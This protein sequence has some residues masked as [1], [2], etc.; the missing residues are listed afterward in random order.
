MSPKVGGVKILQVVLPGDEVLQF[1]PDGNRE[2]I[3]I[4]PGLR[5]QENII[6]ATRSGVLKKTSQNLYYIDNHQKR[7]IPQ[8]REFVIGIILKKN[9]DNYIIDIGGSEKAKISLMVFENS[10]KKTRKEM[11]PGDIIFGQVLVANKDI[12]PELVCI[13]VFDNS[14]GIGALPEDGIMFS[15][16]LHVAR[17]IVNPD[18]SFLLTIS[19]RIKFKIV[20]G[21]NGR[22]WLKA[23]R[24]SDMLAVMNCLLMLE[25]MPLKE[26][27]WNVFRMIDS[28]SVKSR[29]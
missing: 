27:E 2:C 21:F 26:A 12:E 8:K 5:W 1:N 23:P 18:N 13:D 11:K 15:I 6:F 17:M 9:S 7:Y 24:Q 4:G 19:K 14:V 10:S 29:N 16:P 28:F 25:V 20:V 3:F 22:V